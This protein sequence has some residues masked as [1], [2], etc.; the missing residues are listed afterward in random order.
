MIPLSVIYTTFFTVASLIPALFMLLSGLFLVTLKDRSKASFH[1]GMTFLIFGTIP[2]CYLIQSSWYHPLAGYTRWIAAYA[3]LPA[4]LHVLLFFVHYPYSN[5][6]NFAKMLYVF[7]WIVLGIGW[8]TFILLT[9]SKNTIYDFSNHAWTLNAFKHQD[10]VAK[11]IVLGVLFILITGILNTIIVK[12]SERWVSLG[13]LIG[14]L[15]CTIIPSIA[16]VLSREGK[17]ERGTFMMIYDLFTVA[18]M[19][20]IFILFINN[21]RDKTS[22]MAKII[23][24]SLVT[25]FLVL[26]VIS[27]YSLS[28]KEQAF[29][30]IMQREA[31]LVAESESYINPNVK[32]I[33][34][35][36]LKDDTFKHIK[37]AKEIDFEYHK[38]KFYNFYIHSEIANMDEGDEFKSKL[39]Y[40]LNNTKPEFIGYKKSIIKFI[41]SY[42]NSNSNL[43]EGTIQFI[44][45]LQKELL[46]IRIKLNRTNKENILDTIHQF[47]EKANKKT[48]PFMEAV[49]KYANEH[50]ESNNLKREI[51]QYISEM[52][53]EESRFYRMNENGNTHYVSYY[54]VNFSKYRVYEI[55]FDY[56]Y[57]REYINKTAIKFVFVILG[58]VLF[59]LFGFRIFFSNALVKPL[60]ELLKGLTK[61][62][63]G[64]LDIKL[65]VFVEDEIGFLSKSFNKMVRSIRAAKKRLQQYAD[66]LELKVQERTKELNTT[67]E[68]V[69]KLKVQQDGDYF[70]TSLLIKPLGKNLN[71][72]DKVSVRYLVTQK[73]KFEFRKWNEELG[74]D[75]CTSDTIELKGK[76]YVVFLNA[77]AMGK[78][79][80]GAGGALV[81]GSVF[82]SIIDRTSLDKSIQNLYPEKWLKNSFIELQKI[83]ESFE[84]SML[85]SMVMGMVEEETGFM[86]YL[87]AEHPYTILYRDGKA[88]FLENEIMFWKLGVTEGTD[89][90]LFIKTFILKEGDV[91]IAG[92]D[93]RDDILIQNDGMR[94]L[95]ENENLILKKVEEG[96]GNLEKIYEKILQIGEL[97]D[98]LSLLRVEYKN[99]NSNGKKLHSIEELDILKEA[100]EIYRKNDIG[101]ATELLESLYEINPDN[102]KVLKYLAK[103]YFNKKDYQKTL[104]YAEKYV[105]LHPYENQYLFLMSISYQKIGKLKE[106]ADI[107]ERLKIRNPGDTKN[108]LNLIQTYTQ[109][110][111]IER[112]RI[113]T[114]DAIKIEPTNDKLLKLK[115]NIEYQ[116]N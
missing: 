17:M 89:R 82:R 87:N 31:E 79:I 49:Q 75:L 74:G 111:N 72:S 54:Y 5:R 10:I 64:D 115:K 51:Y 71:R 102:E 97:T 13:I 113:L 4:T 66:E 77:D 95:N 18:G 21:T 76:K 39:L 33:T 110:K 63:K 53:P 8:L 93:G 32:Y 86:Y 84:G 29:D 80:Q 90:S 116:N 69:Q 65:P 85:I 24:V 25:F 7:G 112:A 68:E 42:Q 36:S 47:T 55:G 61:V 94:T 58:V 6:P 2:I 50:S 37:K 27:N 12:S 45:K 83:F 73:K 81:L 48:L 105:N 23:G 52:K 46:P 57:Y 106:A 22:F 20:V 108:I 60:N 98:D 41:N 11:F 96:E 34:S 91:L 38:M 15:I 3:S 43:K 26:Q 114:E 62:N 107:G 19:F 1:L 28:D 67:L 9:L 70:L 16:N 109:M 56:I 40:V 59:V 104:F 30:K 103:I 44:A 101:K 35:Y 100:K 78:S 99:K 14:F 88:E 92:S